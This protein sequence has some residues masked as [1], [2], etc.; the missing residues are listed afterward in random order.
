MEDEDEDGDEV[1]VC[2]YYEDEDEDE[3]EDEEAVEALFCVGAV[4]DLI[5][6]LIRRAQPTR[7]S[8][9]VAVAAPSLLDRAPRLPTRRLAA[10]T[11]RMRRDEVE[12]E[13]E[14]EG[15]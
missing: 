4:Y 2:C 11:R 9:K 8:A 5:F 3:D 1:V 6:A 13:V 14:D 10:T 7:P 12:D 15:G